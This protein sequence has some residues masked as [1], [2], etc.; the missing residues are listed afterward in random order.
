MEQRLGL[1]RGVR[2]VPIVIFQSFLPRTDGKNPIGTHLKVF[3]EGLHGIVVERVGF[4]ARIAGSPD[5]RF[6][7][8]CKAASFENSA[9]D[10]FLRQI[11]SFK[12]Q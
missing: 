5:Q 3:I 7:S 12:I 2:L 8:I 10:C 11:T 1:L 4:L 9:L 6:M